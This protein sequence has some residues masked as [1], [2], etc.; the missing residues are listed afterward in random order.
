MFPRYDYYCC[1]K[2]II[3]SLCEEKVTR[4]L[5]RAKENVDCCVKKRGRDITALIIIKNDRSSVIN[6]IHVCRHFL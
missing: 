6:C 4:I 1:P 5:T 2:I 3:T